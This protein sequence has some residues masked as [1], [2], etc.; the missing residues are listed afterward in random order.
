MSDI[1]DPF[2]S[3]DALPDA[4][5]DGRRLLDA[6]YEQPTVEDALRAIFALSDDDLRSIVIEAAYRRRYDAEGAE[7]ADQWW[8]GE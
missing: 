7:A 6:I 5:D 2:D 8:N 4:L 1:H 3:G